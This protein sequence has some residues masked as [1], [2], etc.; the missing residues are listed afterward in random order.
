M[1][2]R[3][4]T[5]V[6]FAAASIDAV[7]ASAPAWRARIADLT[8]RAMA[9]WLA[10]RAID[11]LDARWSG[12]EAEGSPLSR[13]WSDYREETA[14]E[15]RGLRHP[16]TDFEFLLSFFGFERRLYGIVRTERADW[17]AEYASLP[18]IAAHEYWN[19]TDDRPEGVTEAAWEER[20]RTWRGA[21]KGG[22]VAEMDYSAA[23]P[24]P[25]DA[26]ILAALPPFGRRVERRARDL[27]R[28]FF[29]AEIGPPTGR[30]FVA[31]VSAYNRATGWLETEDGIREL[32]RRRSDLERTLPRDVT[33]EMLR[34]ADAGRAACPAP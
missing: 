33:A 4:R 11:G 20:W 30:D 28:E 10:R 15:Q 13:A 5:G 18:G 34:D 12:A 14:K 17:F 26:E 32:A 9:E 23:V 8:A 3:I 21:L 27:A 7:A 19:D 1:S 22:V 24:P 16:D 29:M 31:I 25:S 2:Y 6:V